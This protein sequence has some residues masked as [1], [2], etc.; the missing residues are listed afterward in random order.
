MSN[1]LIIRRH[2][3]LSGLR[4]QIWF[5]ALSTFQKT[6]PILAI[7]AGVFFFSAWHFKLWHRLPRTDTWIDIVLGTFLLAIIP[8]LMAAYGGHVAAEGIEDYE[9]RRSIKLRFWLA[10]FLGVGLAFIQQYRSITR[11]AA[12]KSKTENVE[13]AILGQ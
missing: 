10:F 2:I 13:G 4:L 9:R 7:T 6:A 12:T 11:E 1:W 8:F 5:H 3:F